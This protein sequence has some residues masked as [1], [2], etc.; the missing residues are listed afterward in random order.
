MFQVVIRVMMNLKTYAENHG[1]KI[2]IIF[3]LIGLKRGNKEDI[4]YVM[5]TTTLI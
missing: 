4:V 5:K 3:L 1:K 2:K